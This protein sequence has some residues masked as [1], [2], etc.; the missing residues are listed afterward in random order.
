MHELSLCHS[1]YQVVD[2]ARAG[3][4]V[5][6]VY[7][8]VGQL[9]QVVP[10]TLAYCW[11]LVTADGPLAGAELAIDH[12]PVVVRCASCGEETPVEHALVLVCGGCGSGDT[13]PVRGEEFMVTSLDLAASPVTSRPVTSPPVTS[14]PTEETCHGPLPPA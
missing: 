11:G 3:R 9:R 5:R 7:L 2:R 13:K 6:T 4:E 1:I 10:E 14:P 8:Q 12:V